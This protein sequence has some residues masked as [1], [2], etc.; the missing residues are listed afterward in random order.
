MEGVVGEEG[1]GAGAL[2]GVVPCLAEVVAA[3]R[4][5]AVV[6]EHGAAD[7]DHAGEGGAGAYVVADGFH[8][9]KVRRF[10]GRVV[11]IWGV[12][13]ITRNF[14]MAGDSYKSYNFYNSYKSYKGWMG[15][16][17]GGDAGIT[18]RLSE[19]YSD[20]YLPGPQA[21]PGV[22]H[23]CGVSDPWGARMVLVCGFVC[24]L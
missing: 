9:A 7:V 3:A 24:F 1:G 13:P 4:G 14:F 15:I 10:A 17:V 8:A 5:V 11:R 19:T 6:D 20:G 23:D 18:R 12:L 22:S 21:L 16:T 2:N